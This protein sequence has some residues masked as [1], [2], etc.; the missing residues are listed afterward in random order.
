MRKIL[1]V[2]SPILLCF[3]TLSFTDI[4][5]HEGPSGLLGSWEYVAPTIGWQYQKGA[6]EFRFEEEV[7]KGNVVFKD[8]VI[9]MKNLIYEENKLRAHIIFEGSQIDIFLRFQEDSFKGTVSN[10]QG[11]MRISGSKIS[12]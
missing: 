3:L 5:I 10:S 7:L 2:I 9:P 12:K 4:E 8:V 1:H 6:L 11:Y